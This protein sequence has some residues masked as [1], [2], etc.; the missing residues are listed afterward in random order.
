MAATLT[1]REEL[2]EDVIATDDRVVVRSRLSATHAGEL[3]GVPATG[4]RF[5]AEAVHIWR[6]RTA[7]SPSTGCSATT[8]R[9]SVSSEQDG[10]R[11]VSQA[12]AVTVASARPAPRV[13]PS[14]RRA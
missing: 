2:I 12:L 8:S 6:S 1:D 10:E 5:A 7:C 13:H 14:R 11:R 9:R 3:L 4:R